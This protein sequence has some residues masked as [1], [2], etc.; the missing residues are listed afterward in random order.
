M[1]CSGVW[2]GLVWAGLR[3]AG[4]LWPKLLCAGLAGAGLGSGFC[5]GLLRSGLLSSGLWVLLWAA[6]VRAALLLLMMPCVTYLLYARDGFWMPPGRII[7]VEPKWL[8]NEDT[9]DLGNLCL[10]GCMGC[11]QGSTGRSLEPDI[12]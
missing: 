8:A 10:N 6:L 5:V 12:A 2:A 11:G 9:L 4:L 7:L 1:V 3:W